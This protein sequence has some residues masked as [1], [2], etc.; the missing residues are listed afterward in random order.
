MRKILYCTA[1][2][3]LM[4]L[5]WGEP[6]SRAQQVPV[7][8]GT[9]TAKTAPSKGPAAAAKAPA[10]GTAA[11]AKPGSTRT[12]TG[13]RTTASA[14]KPAAGRTYTRGAASRQT[15][16]SRTTTSRTTAPRTTWRYR[17]MAPSPE[18][19]KEIQDA[20]VSKGYLKPE[21][22]KELGATRQPT[23]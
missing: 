6:A 18:R 15:T 3:T 14:S 23:R 16:A 1:V 9:S 4:A 13:A 22:A 17:Q 21:E 2:V 8:K 20:L 19:Y 10:R 7:R 11:A 12:A 5:A